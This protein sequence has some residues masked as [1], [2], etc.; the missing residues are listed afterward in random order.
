MGTNRVQK[1]IKKV[2][3]FMARTHVIIEVVSMYLETTFQDKSI[4][5]FK[6][7]VN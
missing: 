1:A 6:K 2:S 7:G 4:V 5:S 3:K